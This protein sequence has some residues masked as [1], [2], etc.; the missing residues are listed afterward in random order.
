MMFR[1][2]FPK[3]IHKLTAGRP[4]PEDVGL[5]PPPKDPFAKRVVV[6]DYVLERLRDAAIRAKPGIRRLC[7]TKIEF[8]D[9]SNEEVDVLI[10]ATG[11]RFSLPFF[12]QG[13]AGLENGDLPLYRGL[14][15]PHLHDLFVVGVMKAVCSIWPRSEQQM[16]FIAPLLAGE[17]ALPSQREIDRHTY[18]VLGVPYGNCQFHTHDLQRELARGRRRAAKGG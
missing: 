3:M 11:Y 2:I 4:R 14:M 1:A 7:G 17:Y 6:N 18:P 10:T 8:T 16:R 12:E 5:P 13:L 15:H 9:G